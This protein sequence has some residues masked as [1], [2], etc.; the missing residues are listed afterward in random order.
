MGIFKK[1]INKVL[2]AEVPPVVEK[3]VKKELAQKGASGGNVPDTSLFSMKIEDV[4][5]IPGRGTVVSGKINVG[6]IKLNDEIT[7]IGESQKKITKVVSIEKSNKLVNEAKIGDRVGLLLDKI[8]Q[9]EVKKG[10]IVTKDEN[11]RFVNIRPQVG[12]VIYSEREIPDDSE[13]AKQIREAERQRYNVILNGM[14][15]QIEK[16]S[17]FK[18][19]KKQALIDLLKETSNLYDPF[20]YDDCLT[21]AEKKALG[22]NTRLKLSRQMIDF[23]TEEGLKIEN[24]KEIISTMYYQVCSKE[25]AVKDKERMESAGLAMYVWETSGGERVCPACRVMDGKLCLWSDPTVYSRNKGKDWIPRP[26]TAVQVHPGENVCNK[27]GYCRCTA[28]S[29]EP[30]LLGEL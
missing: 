6:S 27:E 30:E 3:L 5:S 8:K 1:L 2:D 16:S 7:L 14:I 12:P 24:P 17:Y 19:E 21:V 18:H 9:N 10:Y 4:F 23:L 29:Y 13:E 11:T 25:S 28:L 26:K 20:P 15:T 22:L